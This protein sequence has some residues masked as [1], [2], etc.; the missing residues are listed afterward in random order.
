MLFITNRTPQG[1]ARS[2]K[3]RKIRFSV[4]N[5]DASQNL[6]FC[7][8]L[9]DNDYQ[10]IGCDALF[11]Q[12]SDLSPETQVLFYIH[13][14]NNT[15]EK[16]IFP[17]AQ[18]LQRLIDAEKG[19][20]F[21]LVVPVIWPCDD[22]H[23]LA[24]LE[25]YWDDRR[26]A[27]A[28]GF[29]FSRLLGKFDRWRA[30]QSQLP[31]PCVRRISILSHSMGNRVLRNAVALWSKYDHGGQVPLLF[32]NIFMLAPDIESHSLETGQAGELLPECCRN[33]VVYHANDDV[34]MPAS[35]LANVDQV[36]IHKR[37][38]LC[39]NR[40]LQAVARNVYEVD[41]DNFNNRFDWPV[42]HVYFLEDRNGVVSPALNHLLTAMDGGRVRPNVRRFICPL[43]LDV[44]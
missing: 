30:A 12:L 27:D 28:S 5:T 38:G 22:D 1:S 26:A 18:T 43:P 14:F 16:E 15:F 33:L 40:D 29:A 7:L 36:G 37:L 34:A 25:D 44:G 8:R 31:E 20:D 24:L 3:N 41:C 23:V 19:P 39:G 2:R 4:Q 9:G 6:Y 17:Q 10:E 13:G 35:K 42:G 32:R 11:Q 21:A